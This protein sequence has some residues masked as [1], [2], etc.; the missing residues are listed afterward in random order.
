MSC[1]RMLL[2]ALNK[3]ACTVAF[4]IGEDIAIVLNQQDLCR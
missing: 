1:P 2:K 4:T 3:V